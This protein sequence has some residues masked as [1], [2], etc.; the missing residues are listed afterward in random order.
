MSASCARARPGAGLSLSPFDRLERYGD[1]PAIVD[2]RGVEWSHRYLAEAADD[3]AATIAGCGRLVAVAAAN[4]IDSLIAYVAA[5]RAGHPVL[6]LAPDRSDDSRL[7]DRFGVDYVHRPD[8]SGWG[9][10]EIGERRPETHPELAVLLTT[11]GSTGAPKLVRLS[12]GNVDS[13]A[14]AIA[15]YLQFAAGERAMTTLPFHYS[16]GL[17]VI[18]SHLA[19][20]NCVILNQRSIADPGFWQA[21]DT[22]RA[23]SFAG[24][25][26]SF[27]LLERSGFLRDTP[28]ASLRYF[29][30]AGGRLAPDHVR[31][32]AEFAQAHA[33]RFFVMYGQT[34]ASPR[35]AYVPPEL[36]HAHPG[37]I[38]YAIPG[39]KLDLVDDCGQPVLGDGVQGEL[40]YRGPNVMMG[41]AEAAEDL[42][43]GPELT[44][45]RTGDLAVRDTLGMVS[46]TGRKNR[47]VKLFGLRIGLDEVEALLRDQGIAG[48]AHGDDRQ[49]QLVLTEAARAEEMV[50]LVRRRF[51]LPAD[52]VRPVCVPALPRLAS[53][54]VD[55][56]AIASLCGSEAL[57][58]HRDRNKSLG[59]EIARLLG[60][61]L[62][63]ALSFSESSMDSLNYVR[64]S[65]LLEEHLGYVPDGWEDLPIVDLCGLP[66]L[67]PEAPRQSAS[68]GFLANLRA[69]LMLL[70]IPYHAAMA[71]A[72]GDWIVKANQTSRAATWFAELSH[73]FRMPAFFFVAGFFAMLLA[74]KQPPDAWL[75]GR[76]RALMPPLIITILLINPL[77][78]LGRSCAKY[79]GERLV[80]DWV[81]QLMS[82]GPHWIE[83]AW[84]LIFLLVYSAGLALYRKYIPAET[85]RGAEDAP[86]VWPLSSTADFLKFTL[87]AGV[88]VA[89]I[90]FL[91]T[92]CHLN[93]LFAQMLWTSSLV[94]LA[95]LFAIGCIAAS[96]PGGLDRFANLD[97]TSLAVG[98]VSIAVLA[99][100]QQETGP[101][102]RGLTYFLI[103]I[104][105][106]FATRLLAYAYRR[107]LH[108]SDRRFALLVD[109]SLT[110]Y[111][112][113]QVFVV[114][115]VILFNRIDLPPVVEI[116]IISFG[117]LFMSLGVH[118]AVMLVRLDLKGRRSAPFTAA[119][120]GE[121]IGAEVS[122][123][124]A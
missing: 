33:V 59:D 112:V 44:E 58:P 57:K 98:T 3:M 114:F 73:T 68:L 123:K 52:S 50:D 48:A 86:V 47:F 53:G 124:A 105:G 108:R 39:G 40:V 120:N 69:S 12:R 18:N 84:F 88:A 103:P 46:I 93:F 51:G 81:R 113:H 83:H 100:V 99:F 28:P 56:G 26:Y 104:A 121:E 27:E 17:S 24:V 19:T 55:Y 8:Q 42:A 61:S 34:E 115:L 25:P 107:W 75:R 4:A 6:L 116:V 63:P 35:M 118:R 77:I 22:G 90:V 11:S 31:A 76:A 65:L 9:F 10:E 14:L 91:L 5:R 70:G 29:T 97:R 85:P 89:A 62:D 109:A 36:V 37:V 60:N 21:F 95:P 71:Y 1:N 92:A 87:A 122:A 45:L 43:G 101:V 80:H 110:V 74:K 23:T 106:I 82:A 54:K 102:C 79:G 7:I 66:P 41:Y 15:D 67:A 96:R 13:N 117:A 94:S 64:V 78:M 119:L 72:F 32:F 30:Q 16:Y 49:I 111:L 2:E 20:G 38:G